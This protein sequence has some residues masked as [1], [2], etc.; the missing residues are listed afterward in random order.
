MVK[1]PKLEKHMTFLNL[2]MNQLSMAF[3]TGTHEELVGRY[4]AS[5]TLEPTKFSLIKSFIHNTSRDFFGTEIQTMKFHSVSTNITGSSGS[6]TVVMRL[7]AADLAYFNSFSGIFDE[8]RFA[9]PITVH[10][11]PTNVSATGVNGQIYGIGV[12]DFVDSTVLASVAG[13]LMY[14]TAKIFPLSVP[15]T[16]GLMTSWETK[17]LGN[18]DDLW[19]DTGSQATDVAWFKT[20]AYS[21]VSGSVAYGL[22]EWIAEVSFRQLY[23][24]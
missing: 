7:R 16:G 19:I 9:G 20:Y 2:M 3:G 22:S 24:I 13:S 17:L 4:R 18:P 1:A 15:Y 5:A 10:Y 11:R 12:I 14:D 21:G 6:L 23:G 8:Y